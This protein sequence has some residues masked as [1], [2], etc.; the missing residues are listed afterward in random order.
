MASKTSSQAGSPTYTYGY[1]SCGKGRLCAILNNATAHLSFSYDLQGRRT[2]QLGTI[3]GVSA[4]SSQHLYDSYGRPNR[5]VYPGGRSVTY[6]YDIQGRI[7]QVSTNG[8]F[9]IVLASNFV[10][11]YP[12]AGPQSFNYGNGLT[13]YQSR[14]QDYRLSNSTDGPRTKLATY[15]EAGNLKNLNDVSNGALA[16]SYDATGRLVSALN[17]ATG[18]FGSLAW[19][20]DQNGNRQSETRNAGTM[21]YVYSPAG[22]NWLYQRGSDSRSKT[23]NG[24]TAS[25]SGVASF[26]YDGFNRLATSVTASETTTY[27][28]NALGQ[29]IK[30]RNQNGLQTVFHYGQNGELLYERD[31]NGNTKEYVWLEGRPLARIDYGTVIYY[32]HV[33]HLGTPQVMT[34]TKG[35]VEWQA[36]YEPFGKATVKVSTAENNLRLPGQYFDRE[37]GLHYNYFRDYEPSTGRYIEADP[38]G[39]AGG[40]NVYG[41]ANQNPVMFTDLLGLAAEGALPGFGTGAG[42]GAGV[43]ETLAALG[44]CARAVTLIGGA[45]FPSGISQ[46]QDFPKPEG[47]GGDDECA[48]LIEQIHDV[49]RQLTRRYMH[50]CRDKKNQ[51]EDH[52]PA[53][54]QTKLH[55]SRL[56]AK[57]EA[58]NCP[59]P[60]KAYDWLQTP[61]P[62]PGTP[63]NSSPG[64]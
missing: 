34:N 42:I 48:K 64:Y 54:E 11:A 62:L 13:F 63:R 56:V 24:N 60:P 29:R 37:T 61:C 32:Y 20:Y 44:A 39:L 35:L 38:I 55:L 31:A 57:A 22:S 7:S 43:G 6:S 36:G 21:P 19:T 27:T 51:W 49:M 5:I 15:D 23:A 26:T 50:Q 59:V 33:D 18:S 12:F 2:Y 47:C 3:P 10:Y 30:K 1:D 28:Y 16:Y 53:F 40:M 8:G 45:I 58:K 52:V 4:Y 14:D 25:I 17:T 41:Y 46:C 9:D